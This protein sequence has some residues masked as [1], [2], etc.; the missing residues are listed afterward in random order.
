[1][2]FPESKHPPGQLKVD[3]AAGHLDPFLAGCRENRSIKR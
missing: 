3:G 2:I 1:M